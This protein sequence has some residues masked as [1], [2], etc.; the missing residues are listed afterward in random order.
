VSIGLASWLIMAASREMARNFSVTFYSLAN[1][2]VFL[3]LFDFCV[4]LYIQRIRGLTSD[5]GGDSPTSLVLESP[6]FTTYQKRLHVRPWAMIVSV[7]NAEHSLDDFLEAVAPLR[8][9]V[10]IVDDGSADNT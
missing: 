2:I 3:D 10:W 8:D 7:C 6:R 1:V 4:R 9:H 5:G